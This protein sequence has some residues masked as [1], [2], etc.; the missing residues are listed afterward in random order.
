MSIKFPNNVYPLVNPKDYFKFY[1]VNFSEDY[2]GEN[3][4]QMGWD[5]YAPIQDK[6]IDRIVVKYVCPEGHTKVNENL[7]GKKCNIESCGLESMK[8]TRLIQIKTRK[9]IKDNSV[10]TEDALDQKAFLGYTFK[11]KDFITDPRVCFLLFSDWTN[12]FLIFPINKFMNLM[13]D[14]SDDNAYFKSASFKQGNDKKNNIFLINSNWYL[15][16][17]KNKTDLSE[18]IDLKGLE[19]ISEAFIENNIKNLSKEILKIK[20]EDF[21]DIGHTET[22]QEHMSEEELKSLKIKMKELKIDDQEYFKNLIQN[23]ANIINALE[24]RVKNSI[25]KY[26]ENPADIKIDF[27][28]NVADDDIDIED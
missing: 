27:D 28:E 13:R 12:N 15:G 24:P 26:F 14:K 16:S 4:R 9:I 18:F 10:N 8:I 21:L 3:F 11:P 2:V 7:R 23:N 6:G 25:K 5:V 1:K 22:I 20:E 19:G 17:D